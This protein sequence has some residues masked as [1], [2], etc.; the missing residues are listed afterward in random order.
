MRAMSNDMNELLG[1]EFQRERGKG[2][3]KREKGDSQVRSDQLLIGLARPGRRVRGKYSHCSCIICRLRA[4]AKEQRH[5]G[6]FPTVPA[7]CQA[8]EVRTFP[9]PARLNFRA[10]HWHLQLW[11]HPLRP[12]TA[13]SISTANYQRV[14]V[15][16]MPAD[17]PSFVGIAR[18]LSN[19]RRLQSHRFEKH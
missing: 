7:Q 2:K 1:E 3:E 15:I 18:R 17:Q 12:G 9:E 19:I 13:I 6:H 11:T 10:L 8:E 16:V 14:G 4:M 5:P